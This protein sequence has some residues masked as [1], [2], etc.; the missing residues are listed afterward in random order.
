MR[1]A[2]VRL[3]GEVRLDDDDAVKDPVIAVLE[4]VT[5]ALGIS[6][7]KDVALGPLLTVQR[8]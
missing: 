4:M 5:L 6:L 8:D 7:S 1:Q 2:G 3:D